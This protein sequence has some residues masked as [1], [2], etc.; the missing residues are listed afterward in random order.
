MVEHCPSS[1]LTFAMS[2]DE[3]NIEPD[4][5]R[6]IAVTT[7]ITSDGPVEGAFWVTG[8]IPIER[9]DGKPFETL[10]RVTLCSCGC[11]RKKPFCDGIHRRKE[12]EAREPS[13]PPWSAPYP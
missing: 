12:T 1:S 6:Q 11:S 2:A 5:P 8:N 13:G 10:N 3:P 7:D 9:A 4:Y